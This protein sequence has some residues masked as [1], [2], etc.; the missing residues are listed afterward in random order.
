MDPTQKG[1]VEIAV[2]KRKYRTMAIIELK[3]DEAVVKI[4]L[5]FML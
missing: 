5:L 3:D 4:S 1:T 2:S